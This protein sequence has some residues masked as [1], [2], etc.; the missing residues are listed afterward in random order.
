M[1]EECDDMN[2]LVLGGAGYIGSHAVYQ[3]IDKGYKVVVVDN[4]QTGHQEA[5]HPK[6]TFYQG[7]IRNKAFLQV[8]FKKKKLRLLSIL[9]LIVL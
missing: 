1:K 2:I 4:L 7:D 3:L 5:I 6:A 8:Y 9:P